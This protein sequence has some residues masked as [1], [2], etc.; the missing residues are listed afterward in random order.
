LSDSIDGFRERLNGKLIKND[1]L[2][3]DGNPARDVVVESESVYVHAHFI[4]A[5]KMFYQVLVSFPKA[6]VDSTIESK[7]LDSF[8]L[9]SVK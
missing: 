9:R 8:R 1:P 7:F 2:T 3:V 6:N 5:Q 4:L